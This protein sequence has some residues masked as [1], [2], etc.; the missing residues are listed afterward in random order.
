MRLRSIF[1]YKSKKKKVYDIVKDLVYFI[2]NYTKKNLIFQKF[3]K[4]L[5]LILNVPNEILEKRSKQLSSKSFTW[6]HFIAK[7]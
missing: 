5:S 1:F 4:D 7:L 6:M 2:D 3:F